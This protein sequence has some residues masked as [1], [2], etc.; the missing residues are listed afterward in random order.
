VNH[1]LRSLALCSNFP[2]RERQTVFSPLTKNFWEKQTKQTLSINQIKSIK[3][4]A[5]GLI[6]RSNLFLSRRRKQ[7]AKFDQLLT[8]ATRQCVYT[9]ALS[10]T[11]G[12]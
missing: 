6:P 3:E 11:F 9:S 8:G 10:P 1:P 2:T 12:T 7:K 5:P 4:K